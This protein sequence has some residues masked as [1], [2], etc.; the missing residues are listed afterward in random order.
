[1]W[2]FSF[3]K[4]WD[5]TEVWD[6]RVYFKL[7][8][9]CYMTEFRL[10]GDQFPFPPLSCDCQ[11]CLLGQDYM[12]HKSYQMGVHGLAYVCLGILQMKKRLWSHSRSVS[13]HGTNIWPFSSKA[14]S[15]AWATSPKRGHPSSLSSFRLITGCCSCLNSLFE[16]PN[17]SFL[18]PEV[19]DI[20]GFCLRLERVHC[21]LL[22]WWP[23][24]AC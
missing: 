2:T 15:S 9:H 19:W 4:A 6:L 3:K 11:I 24:K 23:Q 22:P 8:Y 18:H 12:V 16:L 20:G 14:F 21:K 5:H 7:H 10:Y 13:I 17:A 1:M